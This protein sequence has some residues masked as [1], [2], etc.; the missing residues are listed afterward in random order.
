MATA[1]CNILMDGH[2]IVFETMRPCEADHSTVGIESPVSKKTLVIL[3]HFS[4][5]GIT[6]RNISNHNQ[7]DILNKCPVYKAL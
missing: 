4:I 1:C 5:Q 7:G 3:D 2:S 6:I